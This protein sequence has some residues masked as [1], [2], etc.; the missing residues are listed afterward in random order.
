[1]K[2]KNIGALT[3]DNAKNFYI[4]LTSIPDFNNLVRSLPRNW[5]QHRGEGGG[6]G[7]SSRV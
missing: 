4:F 2:E 6:G 5:Q 3:I 1:M 7:G